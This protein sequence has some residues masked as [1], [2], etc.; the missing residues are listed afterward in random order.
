MSTIFSIGFDGVST[1]TTLV[2]SRTP[3]RIAAV[4]V[5]STVSNAMP[6]PLSTRASSRYVPPY[7]SS[8]SRTWSPGFSNM[9]SVVSAA[10]PEANENALAPPSSDASAD[11]SAS[12][13]GL[14]PRA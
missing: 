14:P 2:S 5:M 6:Q 1:H 11:W 13:V 10:I 12:R 9:S 8:A 4:S 7:T 3:A